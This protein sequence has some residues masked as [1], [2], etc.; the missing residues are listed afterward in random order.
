MAFATDIEMLEQAQKQKQ[1]QSLTHLCTVS[2]VAAWHAD[3]Q[4]RRED[5]R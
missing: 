5:R 1:K 2:S 3:A 4:S